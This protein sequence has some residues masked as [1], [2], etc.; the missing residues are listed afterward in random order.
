MRPKFL[1]ALTAVVSVVI[2]TV[3]LLRPDKQRAPM[4]TET[5]TS[6][7]DS[8]PT[9]ALHTPKASPPP[10]IGKERSW[11]LESL[12]PGTNLQDRIQEMA[13]QKGV[14]VEVLTQQM[15]IEFSNALHQAISPTIEFYGKIVDENDMPLQEV[16]VTFNCLSVLPETFFT[17]N[18]LS[19]ANGSFTLKNINGSMLDVFLQKTGYVGTNNQTRFIYSSSA[20]CFQPNSNMPVIFHLQKK[21]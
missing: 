17:T 8:R 14:S 12:P 13:K 9:Q 19:D 5:Q 3:C 7:E 4:P 1:L 18:V 20:G 21:E 11:T 2:L 15:S 6:T 10:Q 16:T